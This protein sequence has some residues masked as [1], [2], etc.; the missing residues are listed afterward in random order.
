MDNLYNPS[1]N[2]IELT[3][4]DFAVDHLGRMKVIHRAFS[5]KDGIIMFYAPWCPH[6]NS[7]E[8]KDLWKSLALAMGSSF[9]VA[10]V[11]CTNK[12]GRNDKVAEKAGV[13][14]FPTIKLVTRNGTMVTYEGPRNRSALSQYICKQAKKCNF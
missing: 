1:D 2:V 14:G 3:N 5:G 9:P 4:K 13:R 11:N 12:A 10:A 7:K 6:C 8:T